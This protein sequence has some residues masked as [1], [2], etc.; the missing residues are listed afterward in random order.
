MAATG[1]LEEPLTSVT[2]VSTY[3]LVQRDDTGSVLWVLPSAYPN[4]QLAERAARG[5]N[6]R[7]P[8]PD[9]WWVAAPEGRPA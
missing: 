5:L 3:R 8:R 4:R 9:Q 1:L 2:Q 7:R 6:E